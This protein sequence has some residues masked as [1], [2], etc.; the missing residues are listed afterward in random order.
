MAKQE[1]ILNMFPAGIRNRFCEIAGQAED[2]QEI[3]LG[4]AQ[5][6]RVLIRGKEKYLQ[7]SGHVTADDKG[8]WKTG[9]KELNEILQHICKYSI[10]AFEEEISRGFLSI[11]G[12]HR[13]GLAGQV[14]LREDGSVKNLKYIRFM[15]IRISHE[16]IGAADVLLPHLYQRGK[17]LNTLIIAPPGCGKT[18]IL[19]DLVRQVS[20]GNPYGKGIQVGIV[21]ERSEIA[22]SY[23]GIPQ[24]RVG[25]RTDVMD[26][27]PKVVGMMM[28]IRSMAP[29]V[30]AVDEIGSRDDI[31]AI[32]Q[33]Q[34]CGS[35]IIATIHGDSMEDIKDRT[36]K[37]DYALG[38]IFDR[39]VLL[40]KENGRCMVKKIY[41]QGMKRL[42]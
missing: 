24:N 39:F 34:Q 36:W 6:V 5:P 32:F 27:C 23:M 26:S 20:D 4:I 22:G 38:D 7:E 1:E 41:G 29:K 16:I 31:K 9:E 33:I 3:R 10:Y 40:H 18:T 8:A 35:K 37:E 30:V 15:N 28:L 19:R 17:L 25:K 13:V 42:C 11:Q 2:L 14:V 12:G 21:D